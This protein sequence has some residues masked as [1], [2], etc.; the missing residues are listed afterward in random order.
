MHRS[1]QGK[2]YEFFRYN[3]YAALASFGFWHIFFDSSVEKC[4]LCVGTFYYSFIIIAFGRIVIDEC[5]A[6]NSFVGW[7]VFSTTCVIFWMGE[8]LLTKQLMWSWSWVR[9]KKI[10]LIIQRRHI[11]WINRPAIPNETI[12][13]NRSSNLRSEISINYWSLI[14]D[15]SK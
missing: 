8:W 13:T 12:H 1:R 2:S 7:N 4:F 9:T 3:G 5:L 11:K 15:H 14:T 6:F 10:T